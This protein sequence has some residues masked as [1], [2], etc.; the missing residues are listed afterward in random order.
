MDVAIAQVVKELQDQLLQERRAR[1]E[2]VKQ[3]TEQ[4]KK[5]TNLTC[6]VREL[7]ELL[8]HQTRSNVASS[9]LINA[10]KRVVIEARKNNVKDLN[11]PWLKIA[12][13][14]FGS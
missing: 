6:E 11:K 12:E 10:M 1:E 4:R 14:L 8:D 7:N 13:I 2:N 9:K 3:Y 5:I